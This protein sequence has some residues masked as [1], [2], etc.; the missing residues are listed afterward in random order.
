MHAAQISLN[1]KRLIPIIETMILC[2][3]QE[4]AFCDSGPLILEKFNAMM[5]ICVIYCNCSFNVVINTLQM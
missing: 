1:R 4:I 3:R 2:G 5:A